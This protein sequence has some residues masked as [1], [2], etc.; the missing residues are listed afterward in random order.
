MFLCVSPNLIQDL[1]AV[2]SPETSAPPSPAL[3]APKNY[4]QYDSQVRQLMSQMTLDEKIGQMTQAELGNLG[5][6]TDINS[7][8]LGSENRS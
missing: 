1:L 3:A 7:C 6:L 4:S 2:D 8:F 5:N